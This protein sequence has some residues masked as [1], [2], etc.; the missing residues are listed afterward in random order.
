M[1]K[2]EKERKS[3]IILFVKCTT[4]VPVDDFVTVVINGVSELLLLVV[5]V[6]G[7]DSQLK[8]FLHCGLRLCFP[9]GIL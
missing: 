1:A 2:K 7:G 3:R 4:S 9:L 6:F 5:R 8:L